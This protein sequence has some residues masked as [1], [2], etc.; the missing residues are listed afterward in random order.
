MATRPMAARPAP[1]GTTEPVEL[2]V[3]GLPGSGKTAVG[4]RV[5]ARHDAAFVDLDEEIERVAGLRIPEIF[6]AEGEAGFRR[7]ER[8]AIEGLGAVDE[9]PALT[10]VI[11]PGGGAIVDP[12]NRWRLFRGRRVI[13]LDVRP[14]VAAQ[15]LRRS[16]N[17]R[18]LVVGRDPLGAVRELGSAR[19]RFYAA[20]TRIPGVAELAAVVGGVDELLAT[21]ASAGTVLLRAETKIGRLV[22]GTGV[23]AAEVAGALRDLEARRAILVSEPGAWAAVG[24]RLAGD[25]ASAGLPVERLLLPQGEAAKRLAVIED[26]ARELAR[27]RVERREPIVA[28]GGGALGDAAGFLAATYLRGV[29]FIQVPTTL[30]AQIDSSI[31]G[32]TGVGLPEG[33]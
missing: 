22:I 8:A 5:A 6:E 15:R 33:K 18:P 9:G 2:V 23:L 26:A 31:G 16:P 4:R 25:L 21:P 29:P 17:V 20:G 3:V 10:R 13:W 14:E 12:R 7:R 28:I 30:V 1:A 32:K 27:L 24:S 11:A 19:G